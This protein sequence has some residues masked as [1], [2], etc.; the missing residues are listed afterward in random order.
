MSWVTS[1]FAS[2]VGKKHIMAVTGLLLCGF[3]VAHLSGN[4]LLVVGADAFNA[5][6]EALTSNKVLLYTAE[7]ILF[8]IFASHIAIA[9]RLTFENRRAESWRHPS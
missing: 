5:Y 9:T 6:A 4:M 3:L 2:S 1:Y 8:L 7:T